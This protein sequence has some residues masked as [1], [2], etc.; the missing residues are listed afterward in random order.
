MIVYMKIYHGMDVK[1][2]GN[3][4]FYSRFIVA[5]HPTKNIKENNTDMKITQISRFIFLLLFL[6]MSLHIRRV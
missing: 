2:A 1:N 5:Y 4:H 6:V 3:A